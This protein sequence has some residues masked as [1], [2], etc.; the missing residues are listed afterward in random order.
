MNNFKT[1]MVKGQACVHGADLPVC[2]V[3]NVPLNMSDADI[4]EWASNANYDE[5]R[6]IDSAMHVQ[7]MWVDDD[8]HTFDTP[9]PHVFCPEAFAE[10]CLKTN[11]DELVRKIEHWLAPYGFVNLTSSDDDFPSLSY[12][13][14]GERFFEIRIQIGTLDGGEEDI[15]VHTNFDECGSVLGYSNYFETIIYHGDDIKSAVGS[16]VGIHNAFVIYSELVSN[17]WKVTS[18]GGG[19]TAWEKFFDLGYAHISNDSSANLIDEVARLYQT[20]DYL[21][22][23]LYDKEHE[24]MRDI[25]VPM[26][27]TLG[28]VRALAN[29]E[30]RLTLG[31]EE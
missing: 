20:C 18:T 28:V 5:W 11:T 17:D 19:C 30:V 13:G 23:A 6:S 25:L 3:M 12:L 4:Y 14:D 10:E 27:D 16:C 7:S 9:N 15:F 21:N 2:M 24:H 31:E 22:I 26:S 8:I 1:V 29:A